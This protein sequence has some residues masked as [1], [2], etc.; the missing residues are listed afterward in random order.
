MNVFAKICANGEA[1]EE[2]TEKVKEGSENVDAEEVQY[3]V[4][5]GGVS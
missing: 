5:T 2:E 3:V 4:Q 1:C